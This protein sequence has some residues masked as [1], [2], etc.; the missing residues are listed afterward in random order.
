MRKSLSVLAIVGLGLTAGSSCTGHDGQDGQVV[1]SQAA[2]LGHPT[3]LLASDSTL[4]AESEEIFIGR[5]GSLSLDPFSGDFIV[6]D[7]LSRVVY[8]FRRDGQFR[9]RVGRPGQGP[10][11]FEALRVSFV[12]DDS[13]LVAGDTRRLSLIEFDRLS[14]RFRSE[15]RTPVGVFGPSPAVTVGGGGRRLLL[16]S[17][18]QFERTALLAIDL[19]DGRSELTGRLP[20]EYLLSMDEGQMAFTGFYPIFFLERMADE[21]IVL[22]FM[23][24]DRLRLLDEM[25]NAIEE[26]PVPTLFRKGLAADLWRQFATGEFRHGDTPW[27]AGASLNALGTLSDGRIVTVHIESRLEGETAARTVDGVMYVSLLSLGREPSCVDLVVE[28]GADDRAL[29]T[30]HADTLFVLDRR[31]S[32]EEE[33]EP[34]MLRFPLLEIDCPQQ[35]L[36]ESG[37]GSE[38]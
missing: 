31:I 16:P 27:E 2:P 38:G 9:M 18:N 1:V 19:N 15:V 8:V 34:W 29:A 10:G 37:R 21:R 28:A 32:G 14:G 26:R 36:W 35:H 5:P 13:T 7:N 23:G 24:V 33:L 3:V 30:I 25:G 11:E 20:E 6:A 4:L 12:L 22:G 17:L